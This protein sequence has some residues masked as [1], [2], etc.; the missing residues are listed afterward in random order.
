MFR[1]IILTTALCLEVFSANGLEYSKRH[2]DFAKRLEDGP[3]LRT[4]WTGGGSLWLKVSPNT[5]K[6]EAQ[7]AADSVASACP[8]AIGSSCTV[9]IYYGNMREIANSR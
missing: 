1:T 8:S 9:H 5:N 2:Y 7:A 6:Q 4:E 3:V